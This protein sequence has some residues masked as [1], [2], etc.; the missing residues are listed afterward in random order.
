[1]G[2]V[3][4]GVWDLVALGG[5]VLA[6]LLLAS[7]CSLALFALKLMQF[8]RAGVGRHEAVREFIDRHDAGE[9]RAA[10]RRLSEADGYLA[11]IAILAVRSGDAREARLRLEA[12]AEQSF[13][14]LER[15]LR[16]LD[17]VA[18]TAPLLGLF[19]TVLGMIEAFQAL[20]TAGSQ[21][22]PG[23]LAGGI[24]VAL[25]TTAAGLAVA[26]PVSIG[27]AW[28]EGRLES[29]RAMAERVLSAV[30]IPLPGTSP[31]QEV[32]THAEFAQARAP[33]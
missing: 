15:G 5:P 8:E 23:V 17:M 1:M 10:E 16:V 19:G 32:G 11:R 33:A 25:L 30:A 2:N 31:P 12:E 3:F 4:T 7:V 6:I 9:T 29:D 28:L 20:Q 13:L 24:W 14:H 18:Q 26:M 21:V 27:L 22:D